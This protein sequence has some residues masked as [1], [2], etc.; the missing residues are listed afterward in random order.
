MYLGASNCD[1][2]VDE[3][4]GIFSGGVRFTNKVHVDMAPV[5]VVLTP[6]LFAS[7]DGLLELLSPKVQFI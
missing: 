1:S 3:E 5:A 6:A 7:L 4:S 2:G